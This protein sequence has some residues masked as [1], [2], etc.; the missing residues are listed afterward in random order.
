MLED[1]PHPLFEAE[2]RID[3]SFRVQEERITSGTASEHPASHIV[4]LKHS[5]IEVGPEP[6]LR[7][8][9]EQF[10]AHHISHLA[11]ELARFD[12]LILVG[13]EIEIRILRD[14]SR[15]LE[16]ELSREVVYSAEVFDIFLLSGERDADIPVTELPN[17]LEGFD[18]LVEAAVDTPDLIV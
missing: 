17:L 18:D 13:R 10:L 3:I 11:A 4:V 7:A 14:R 8:E 12:L 2:A 16:T 15:E 6:S 5:R 9:A 1:I